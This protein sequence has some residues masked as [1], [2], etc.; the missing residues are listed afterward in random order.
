MDLKH[1]PVAAQSLAEEG[2]NVFEMYVVFGSLILISLNT[3]Q[4]E[5]IKSQMLGECSCKLHPLLPLSG[6]G[7]WLSLCQAQPELWTAVGGSFSSD[8]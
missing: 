2:F 5:A 4:A 1:S 3:C 6:P 8:M 7:G